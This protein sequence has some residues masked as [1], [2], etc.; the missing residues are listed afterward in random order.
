[1]EFAYKESDSTFNFSM[2]EQRYDPYQHCGST[3]EKYE[4]VI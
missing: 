3:I 4:K 1:M 2:E